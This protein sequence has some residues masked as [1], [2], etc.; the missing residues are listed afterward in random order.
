[1]IA[2][3]EEVVNVEKSQTRHP[4][5]IEAGL[6]LGVKVIPFAPKN[7]RKSRSLKKRLDSVRT[8]LLDVSPQLNYLDDK[9]NK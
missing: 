9:S 7:I 4:R 5:N 1:M 8:E 6:D 2:S 3:L